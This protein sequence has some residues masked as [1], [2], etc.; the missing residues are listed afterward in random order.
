MTCSGHGKEGEI[1]DEHEAGALVPLGN[2]SLSLGFHFNIW[3]K[4]S[5]K[6][7]EVL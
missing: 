2:C 3:N 1:K 5:K 4:K 6:A 7:K